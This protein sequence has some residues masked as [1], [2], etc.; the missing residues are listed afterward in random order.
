MDNA[1]PSTEN[2]PQHHNHDTFYVDMNNSQL[3]QKFRELKDELQTM[4]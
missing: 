1:E 4:K 3:I 2:R